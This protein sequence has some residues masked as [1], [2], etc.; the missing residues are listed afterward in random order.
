MSPGL[1]ES[2]FLGLREAGDE[3]S[4]KKGNFPF[5]LPSLSSPGGR[6]CSWLPTAAWVQGSRLRM[7][8]SG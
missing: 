4:K 7:V 5:L 2:L 8:H 1:D 3:A 6:S